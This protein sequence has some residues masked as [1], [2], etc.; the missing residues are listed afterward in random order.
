[1]LRDL[2]HRG[3]LVTG[4][5]GSLLWGRPTFHNTKGM[6]FREFIRTYEAK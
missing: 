5:K 4:N 1:M 6:V 2:F 3:E